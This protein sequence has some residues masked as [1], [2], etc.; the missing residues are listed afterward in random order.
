MVY[1]RAQA[2]TEGSGCRRDAEGDLLQ[3]VLV[4]K[5]LV[6][7]QYVARVCEGGEGWNGTYEI[8]ERVQLLAH[9]TRLLPPPRYLAVHEVEEQAQRYEAEG[10]V[11]V[12]VVVR[13]VLEAVAERRHDRHDA[14]EACNA[15]VSASALLQNNRFIG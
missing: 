9:Q 8:S 3:P 1:W 6:C 10:E 14:A 13:V 4:L 7:G 12:G 15:I 2:E 11:Q 5:T